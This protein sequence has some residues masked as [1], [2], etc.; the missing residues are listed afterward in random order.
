MKNTNTKKYI[1]IA[2]SLVVG[3]VLSIGLSYVGAAFSYPAATPPNG[4]VPLPVTVDTIDQ[5]KVGGLI[6]NAFIANE[7]A[8]FDMDTYLKQP[9][10]GGSATAISPL[11]I[12]GFDSLLNDTYTVITT[13][14]GYVQANKE[15]AA[16]DELAN[17]QKNTLCAND[18]GHIVFCAPSGGGG[19][20]G[21]GS[22]TLSTYG[23]TTAP[24]N[25]GLNDTLIVCSA[26]LS[27]P[28]TNGDQLKINYDYTVTDPFP[29]KSSGSCF[30]GV[31]KGQINVDD[32]PGRPFFLS[33]KGYV[34][35]DSF[36]FDEPASTV[37]NTSGI[38][39]C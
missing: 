15:L 18:T 24:L 17:N 25:P 35:V 22:V 14:T 28:S 36:C 7:A 4:N 31:P 3:L 34:T 5:V 37:L 38:P 27:A 33:S 9:V 16:P 1:V 26:T 2:S 30:L 10:F 29:T 19:G 12:G 6:V 23:V 21:S 39:S 11:R 13:A 8:A 32:K 20:G